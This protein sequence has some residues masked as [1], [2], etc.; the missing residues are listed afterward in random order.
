MYATAL[1][2]LAYRLTGSLTVMTP[3]AAAVPAAQPR[4]LGYGA[5]DGTARDT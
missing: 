2:L 5:G 1:P 3:L 4:E